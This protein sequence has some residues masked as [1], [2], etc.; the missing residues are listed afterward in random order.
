MGC[1]PLR[2][3]GR[4]RTHTNHRAALTGV[5]VLVHGGVDVGRFDL[6][7]GERAEGVFEGAEAEDG[8]FERPLEGG[9]AEGGGLRSTGSHAARTSESRAAH[10]AAKK[11]GRGAKGAAHRRRHGDGERQRLSRRGTSAAAAIAWAHE[12]GRRG[13]FRARE[14]VVPVAAKAA[15]RRPRRRVEVGGRRRTQGGRCSGA[16]GPRGG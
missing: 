5:A 3:N 2:G 11:R 16:R 12:G 13:R 4:M 14:R 9:A 7:V 10:D 1:V 8:V 6:V 15:A